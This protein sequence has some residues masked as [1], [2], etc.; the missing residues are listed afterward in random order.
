MSNTAAAEAL[1]ASSGEG[2]EV[3]Y[4]RSDVEQEEPKKINHPL[5]L[6]AYGF[7]TN[8]DSN[9]RVTEIKPGVKKSRPMTVAE[10]ER[11]ERREKKWRGQLAS[12][13]STTMNTKRKNKKFI[14]RLRKG[15][16]DSMRGRVW[17]LLSGGIKKPG[18]YEGIV[19]KTSDAMLSSCKKLIDEA[20]A[21]TSP[22]TS[23]SSFPAK[24][25]S[26]EVIEVDTD[27]EEDY[28]YSKI[29]TAI[30]DTI[31]RDIHR[32]FPRHNLFYE[33]ERSYGLAPSISDNE[34]NGGFCDP[35]LAAMIL[36][37]ESDI[38]I[39]ASGGAK[40]RVTNHGNANQTPGGQAALRRVLRAYSY[41]DPD[42]GYCQGMNFIA[43]MFLT[44]MSEE[45]AFWL[46][47]GTLKLGACSHYTLRVHLI[48][49]FLFYRRYE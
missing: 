16:P 12:W 2:T 45:E 34:M 14:K 43:G 20:S 19:K 10:S 44:L 4:N 48:E 26:N 49:C 6:D 38:K 33:A 37:L 15:I 17:S 23:E 8:V 46:L 35:E 47:V 29:F 42:V 3:E 1:D 13:N 18:Y 40:E 31:E 11:K 28:I 41:H 5:K 25:E 32:T 36:N 22:T 27:S 7:I 39:T 30:Q 24:D 9:G 21:K